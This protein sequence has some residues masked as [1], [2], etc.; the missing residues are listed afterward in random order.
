MVW[1]KYEQVTV[2]KDVTCTRRVLE[3]WPLW[4]VGNWLIKSEEQTD[5][6]TAMWNSLA[7]CWYS[8]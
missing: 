1:K 5:M 6:M 4:P 8:C 2:V 7:V 3:Q